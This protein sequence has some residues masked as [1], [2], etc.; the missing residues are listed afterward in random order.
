[1]AMMPHER[2]LV[3]NLKDKPFALI[4]VNGDESYGDEF[5]KNIEKH[6]VTWRSFK[7]SPGGDKPDLSDAWNLEGWPTLYLIDA[8]GIIRKVWLGGPEDA[9]EIDREVEKLLTD[10][11]KK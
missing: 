2:S 1:V 10:A 11:E 3:D 9:K 4:G 8:K 5:K 6:K 7:N